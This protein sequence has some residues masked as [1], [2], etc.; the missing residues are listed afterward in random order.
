M[1]VGE[2][3]NA[4]KEYEMNVVKILGSILV[5]L[6]LGIATQS[7]A[8]IEVGSQMKA[9]ELSGDDGGRLDSKPWSSKELAGKV[10]VLFYVDPD[11]KDLNEEFGDKLK[12]KNYSLDVINYVA[13]IN[14]EATWLP[15]FAIGSSLKVK[16]RK[17]P[18]TLYLK[19]YTRKLIKEAK[20][21][22]ED[23]NVLI[24]DRNG[25]V[26]YFK[27]GKMSGEEMNQAIALIESNLAQK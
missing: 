14:M 18:S 27:N 6:S 16:Q 17:F 22:D 5:W 25:K 8:Q 7:F 13:I 1:E 26:L 10:S 24:L 20:F 21:V 9:F 4:I 11:F 2:N 15:N 19:D 3:S 23:Y 12:E